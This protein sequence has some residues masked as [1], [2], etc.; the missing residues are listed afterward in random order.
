LWQTSIEPGKIMHSI[1][2]RQQIGT[3]G[4][5]LGVAD[6]AAFLALFLL[7]LLWP[8]YAAPHFWSDAQAHLDVLGADSLAYY[9][10]VLNDVPAIAFE[11]R[12]L[13]GLIVTPLK[14]T[15]EYLFG[16]SAPDAVYVTFRTFGV[17]AP[18]LTYLLARLHL[19]VLPS[20]ALAL[21]SATTM[22]VMFNSVVYESYGLTL[23][24][25]IAAL[26]AAT[27]F[28]RLFPQAATRNS[29]IAAAVAAFV[30]AAAGWVSLTLL[31]VLLA[32]ILPP[33]AVSTAWR[34]SLWGGVVA[35]TALVLLFVPSLLKSGAA[36][37]QGAIAARYFQ[38]ENLLSL[39]AWSNVLVADFL[40]ALAYPGDVLVGSR[41][42]DVISGDNW[43]GAIR[44]QALS[45]PLS[46]AVGALFL[47][48]M[49]L[50]WKAVGK[51]DAFGLFVL[52][53]WGA[54]TATLAFYVMWT[55]EEASLFAAAA[56]PYQ[57]A[58]AIAGRTQIGPERGRFADL[59]LLAMAIAVAISNFSVMT[60]TADF[61]G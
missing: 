50:S 55:P 40:A 44:D 58:L 47:G 26:I 59:L 54:L 39:D 1:T 18:P 15:Y 43:M 45:A 41:Y 19:A 28:H 10:A 23:A 46:W 35:G 22:V 25:G 48:L 5:S 7:A 61:Y 2:D 17:L 24:A 16:L 8:G 3:L 9:N 49:L 12:P 57:M 36:E 34:A 33:R 52:A 4:A 32:F 6:V 13:F 21:F 30:S 53:L 42:P 37:A 14:K 56:W 31:S 38:P 20:F 11:R 51:R 60:A 27:V 29:L